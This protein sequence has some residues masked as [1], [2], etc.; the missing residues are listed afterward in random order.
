M[1]WFLPVALAGAGEGSLVDAGAPVDGPA[2]LIPVSPGVDPSAADTWVA[3]IEARGMDA[4]VFSVGPEL[5]PDEVSGALAAAAQ[6]LVAERGGYRVA[7]HGWGGVF[8][9]AA[10]LEAE[11]WALVGVPLG[12]QAVPGPL[13]GERWPWPS[14][15]LGALPE[16]PVSPS[17]LIAY[18]RWVSDLPKLPA[19]GA[20]ALLVASNLDAV[21]PPEAVRL[22]SAG[23]PDRTWERT[24]YLGLE[25]G[26]PLHGDLLS[27]KH[28]AR[29]VARYLEEGE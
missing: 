26:D 9:L 15:L 2:V 25:S 13:E 21:A 27:D 10:G 8:A 1:I 6:T 7:A 28:L 18:R 16:A 23:W 3:A 5:G 14:A 20:P 11:R 24:G 17:V 4:W 12:S 22:P 19:P 29:R